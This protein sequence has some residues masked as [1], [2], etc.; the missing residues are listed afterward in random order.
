M[1]VSLECCDNG[2]LLWHKSP[3][4]AVAHS[5][6]F[7]L[8][9]WD[10]LFCG[11]GFV[12]HFLFWGAVAKIRKKIGPVFS[13]RQQQI[14]GVELFYRKLPLVLEEISERERCPKAI[15]DLHCCW[16]MWKRPKSLC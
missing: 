14:N 13:L 16:M 2:I 9:K 11:A 5:L 1:P 4:G 8:T 15:Y 6:R 10:C 7:F 12:I 3:D